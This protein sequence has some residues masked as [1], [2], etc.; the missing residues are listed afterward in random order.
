MA[1]IE[2][3]I[4]KTISRSADGRKAEVVRLERDSHGVMRS[5]THHNLARIVKIR[6]KS[7]E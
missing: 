7:C 1:Y 5:T 3:M 2:A 4:E 6:E